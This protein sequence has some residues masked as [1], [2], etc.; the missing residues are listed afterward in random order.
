MGGSLGDYLAAGMQVEE[1]LPI[2]R[3][4]VIPVYGG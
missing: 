4:E 2:I 1:T 3:G